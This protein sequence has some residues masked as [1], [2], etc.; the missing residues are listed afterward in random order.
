MI[1]TNIVEYDTNVSWNIGKR[2]QDIRVMRGL[3]GVEVAAFLDINKNQLS[4][5]EN[6]KANCTVQ[7]LFVLS[8]LF[9][10]SSDYLLFG[11]L[12]KPKMTQQQIEAI[13]AIKKAF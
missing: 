11:T 13:E 9:E 12:I 8:Q 6:G 7:Q 2:I 5:I 1:N 4:R 10:C 3:S